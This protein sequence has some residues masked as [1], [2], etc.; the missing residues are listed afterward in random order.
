MQARG[1]VRSCPCS[2][3]PRVCQTNSSPARE[4][5]FT[6]NGIGGDQF[7]NQNTI[8]DG[9]SHHGAFRGSVCPEKPEGTIR[10][11]INPLKMAQHVLEIGFKGQARMEISDL[12]T[13]LFTDMCVSLRET[14]KWHDDFTSGDRG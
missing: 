1:T 14:S 8:D 9:W 6:W 7:V 10:L 4:I 5:R 11:K 3:L 13:V 12:V 2:A